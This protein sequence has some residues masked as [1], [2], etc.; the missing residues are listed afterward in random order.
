MPEKRA[1]PGNTGQYFDIP[2]GRIWAEWNK[3]GVY[4]RFEVTRFPVD[5]TMAIGKGSIVYP[6]LCEL[7]DLHIAMEQQLLEAADPDGYAQEGQ[8]A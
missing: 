2:N 3:K 6:V 7:A 4:Q 1:K 8:N 5:V